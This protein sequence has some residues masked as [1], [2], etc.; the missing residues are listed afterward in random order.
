MRGCTGG[1]A[2]DPRRPRRA[3]PARGAGSRLFLTTHTHPQP[4]PAQRH[5][6]REG[7]RGALPA[8]P[9]GPTRPD[10]TRTAAGHRRHRGRAPREHTRAAPALLPLKEQSVRRAAPRNATLATALPLIRSQLCRRHRAAAGVPVPLPGARRGA[11][12]GPAQRP[13]GTKPA[14]PGSFPFPCR[15]WAR[16]AGPAG[17]ACRGGLAPEVWLPKPPRH[18][19]PP[20]RLRGQARRA[21]RQH[22]RARERREPQ[23][24]QS[25]PDPDR[26][27]AG[28]GGL[29]GGGWCP[30][31]GSEANPSPAPRR[32]PP[33]RAA[34]RLRPPR[35]SLPVRGQA[36]RPAR[37][38]RA[39]LPRPNSAFRAR[40]LQ[41]VRGQDRSRQRP[42]ATLC[43]WQRGGGAGEPARG[44]GGEGETNR[45]RTPRAAGGR[46]GGEPRRGARGRAI[47]AAPPPA[48][49][50][51]EAAPSPRAGSSRR[52]RERR[53]ARAGGGGTPAAA[54]GGGRGAEASGREGAGPAGPGGGGGGG[55]GAG[56]L[57][58]VL[59]PA[60]R[61]ARGSHP[62][63]LPASREGSGR[64]SA[65]RAGPGRAGCS[66]RPP[67][68][69]SLPLPSLPR[70][71]RP[72]P[73]PG[74]LISR[75]AGARGAAG[76]GQAAPG[77]TRPPGPV[78]WLGPA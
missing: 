38:R 16:G 39:R 48:A 37:P 71:G 17:A 68:L 70:P 7:G 35:R 73:S 4:G 69:P 21:R 65:R 26:D 32:L 62:L 11:H 36:Q 58:R 42:V 19:Q 52:K 34:A 45:T 13:P 40:T 10:R 20:G 6:P 22:I 2:Q 63:R 56:S 23:H 44:G 72:L 25:D 31:S 61:P 43:P 1:C 12:P 3:A 55:G 60:P 77:P 76:L 49:G 51:G 59:G 53:A 75:Q 8:A 29:G 41:S 30:G 33:R 67:S 9:R 74:P 14:A 47:P 50:R 27:P 54:G 57:R 64:A 24:R 5:I 18:R 78:T 28:R 66:R 46:P 15:R